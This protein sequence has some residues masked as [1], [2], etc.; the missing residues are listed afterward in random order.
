MLKICSMS[1]FGIS[2]SASSGVFHVNQALALVLLAWGG[3][4][5]VK[6]LK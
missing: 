1:S 2:V 5:H 4:F 3:A 6:Q